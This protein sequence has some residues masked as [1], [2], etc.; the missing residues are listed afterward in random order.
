MERQLI[1]NRWQTPDG[2]ILISKHRHDYVSHT[3][4]NG[5]NYF[6]D[7]GRDYVRHTVNNEPMKD[8]CVYSDSPF[9]EIRKVVFRGTFNVKGMRIWLPIYKMS[10]A[11]LINTILYCVGGNVELLDRYD[12]ETHCY[13]RELLYRWDKFLTLPEYDYTDENVEKEPAYKVIT[14]VFE[15]NELKEMEIDEIMNI[16]IDTKDGEGYTFNFE[17]YNAVHELERLMSEKSGIIFKAN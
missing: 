6:I 13:A 15:N 17:L 8:L 16:L 7:G 11:H 1:C 5:D 3:D 10:D 9:D 2:T 12:I 4:K 14:E